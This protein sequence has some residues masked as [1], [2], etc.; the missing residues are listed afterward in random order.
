MLM[1]MIALL[2]RL[3]VGPGSSVL[4]ALCV[5]LA[6]LSPFSLYESLVVGRAG[7][8]GVIPDVS[9]EAC[10]LAQERI[11]SKKEESEGFPIGVRPQ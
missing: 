6:D 10:C 1:L 5:L 3:T 8:C 2:P 4:P 11:R 7:R 9:S